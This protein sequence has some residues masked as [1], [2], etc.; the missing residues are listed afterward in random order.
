MTGRPERLDGTPLTP[1]AGSFHEK[2]EQAK[3]AISERYAA[4][5]TS[6]QA[7]INDEYAAKIA[8]AMQKDD[9]EERNAILER[10]SLERAAR[11]EAAIIECDLQAADEKEATI[12]L[13]VDEQMA[14]AKHRRRQVNR[15][16]KR[17]PGEYR[18]R[19]RQPLLPTA[20]CWLPP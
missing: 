2:I 13:L 18:Y 4:L 15:P 9:P 6:L 14:E 10:L 19:V 1:A 8:D 11:L 20:R 5:K 3:F 12:R 16:S 7:L 17:Q